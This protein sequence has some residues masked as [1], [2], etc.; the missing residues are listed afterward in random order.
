MSRRELNSLIRE[1]AVTTASRLRSGESAQVQRD[2]N[3]DQ[4]VD[5][6]QETVS[7]SQ[8]LQ[9]KLV[10]A[11]EELETVRADYEQQLSQTR[12]AAERAK[13]ENEDQRHKILELKHELEEETQRRKEV[14]C[15][16]AEVSES[17]N[18][19][20][21]KWSADMETMRMRIELDGLKQLEEVRRQ[22]DKERE[23]HREELERDATLI[24]ELKRK[25]ATL[26]S[27]VPLS[28][29]GAV[30]ELH[31]VNESSSK[32]DGVSSDQSSSSGV[33]S[34]KG[35]KESSGHGGVKHVTFAEPEGGRSS[36][37]QT[38]SPPD[39]G[40]SAHSGE[41]G[42][43][44]SGD[45]NPT[46]PASS[47]DSAPRSGD[48]GST[49]VD[50]MTI[51]GNAG[52]EHASEVSDSTGDSVSVGSVAGD[53]GLLMQQLTQ[54]VQTQT[55]M[56]V[57]QTR[58]MSAQGLPP[59][60]HYSGE[61]IQSSEEGFDRWIEQFE[62]RAKLVGWSEDHKRYNLKML[63]DKSAFQTY[64]LLP[65]DVK[66]SYSATVEALRSRFKPV[67]IEELR[68]MEFH[69]LIQTDQSVE[70]LGLAL[71]RLAKRA[72]P[73][74]KGKDFD[75]LVK[76]RFFQA[77]LPRWQ[78]KLGA[79]KP[80][81]SFDELFNRAR[82]TERREQQYCEV[83][84]ERKDAQQ[85][86]K[87][88]EKA[89]TQ[90]R[91]EQAEK[92][93]NSEKR[94][95][96]SK[97]GQGQGP[98]CHNCHRYGHIAKFCWDK[99]KRGAEA[100]GKQKDSKTHLVTCVD[101]LSDKELEQELSKRR[102]DK[103][104]QL[105]SDCVES[106]VNIV[107]GAVGPSYWLQISVEG[108][109][110]SA[111]VDTGSQSTII[112]RSLLHKVFLHLK[113]HGK[114]LPTL[115]YPC[116][117]F[118]GKGGHPIGVSAQVLF[119]LS[120]DGKSTT[121]P[122]FVQ[123]DSEQE[124]LLG[125]NVLPALGISLVRANGQKFT[126]SIENEAEPAHINLVQSVT[127]PG[128]KGRFVKGRI[129][130]DPS[131][132][133]HLLFEPK[134]E[135]LEPLGLC[136]QESI[137]TVHS[138]GSVLIPLQNFQGMPVRLERGA[139][140]GVA[141]Q[142]NL[143][144]QVNIDV[145][146]TVDSELPHDHSRCATVKALVN[147]PERLEKLLKALDLPV[148]KL[149]PVELEKLKEVLAESTDVFALDDSELGCTGLVQHSIDT[150]DHHPVKQPPYRTPVV[151]REKIEQ[152]VSDMQ[153][154]GVVKPSHSPWAS[155]IVL[156]PKKDGS[157][158]FCVDFRRL[159]SLTRKDVY[160]LPRVED[161]LDTL[162]EAKYFTSLDLASGYWQVELDQDARAKSAFTT[163]HG[164]FE[165][166]RMPF[167]LCNA[168]ATFQRLMQAVLSGLEW[169]SCFA[170]LDDILIASRTFDDHL[171][172]LREVFGR[173]REA[174]LRLKPK[175]CL[176][177]RDEVP[178]LGHV[179]STQGI[180]PDPSK[181]EKV[182][183]FP[184]PSDVTTLRQFVGL[185]SYYRRF[186]PGFAKIAAPLHALTKKDVPFEWTQECEAAFC[187]LKELLITAPVLAYPRFGHDKEF[188]LETD[189][190]GIGLGAVLS[191][192]QDDGHLHPIAY[193]SRS[194]N[195]HEKNYCI[196][197]L[198][199]LGLVWAVRYFR[200]Y[201]LGHHTTVYTDH[202]ACLSLLNTPRPSGKL[203]RWALT[204][205]E[206]NLTL[207]HRS[208][209]QNVNA[210]ALSR[211]PVTDS[212]ISNSNEILD[213][214]EESKSVS[215]VTSKAKCCDSVCPVCFHCSV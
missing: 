60:Q 55:A 134:Y 111:L 112:S 25:L 117:K 7:D 83:A 3:E 166:V 120:V 123:P 93:S 71:Q 84:E 65:D 19:V 66:A 133:E 87:K 24:A 115:D 207:K 45:S 77:L 122:V 156:V 181:T 177:L 12:E 58:A 53:K 81:E 160:P 64:R 163:H 188:I 200:P 172:H 33:S 92:A 91:K 4:T 137:L 187:K 167:G 215:V 201:L 57:A 10:M 42:G 56:V 1:G 100:P 158:R 145:P 213:A 206:M 26:E 157:L 61:G 43:E 88:V 37:G 125:S 138:D 153:K 30:S 50:V 39:S 198:E 203:A 67:D 162:G 36:R 27:A 124:C 161:I 46:E 151:Y 47:T 142:C 185:A 168:P 119:T 184:T 59:M 193:A 154:Q 105:A 155:P 29:P 8:E 195:P 146:Q 99:Q 174:G 191:Q 202:S 186:V 35:N 17:V 14:E 116:T 103:E 78:R 62:E 102:L 76:G 171:R 113:K 211:N 107:T 80:D 20:N 182:K 164:L 11:G 197:E 210:D 205:Q 75:R 85:K 176:L 16:L 94:E 74:L 209:R 169:R 108:L 118:K 141:R 51:N 152:M 196:S 72:F 22:F 147:S 28:D 109:A 132:L 82:T 38:E 48:L 21:D 5:G 96:S 68:G 15:E 44:N 144:D 63:L 128:Q 189:A 49:S 150:G 69:Q 170:Y 199:T 101:E 73:M 90:P 34:G 40:D 190:S 86:T 135:S 173:L 2:M 149:N 106:S 95:S 79:P 208:G 54:L 129:E 121:V 110:V 175:K 214:C 178:Y 159:N 97:Q 13:E 32:G 9:Q 148:D 98:Q 180:R 130:G 143:P 139:E 212:N 114:T 140:L 183:L 70:A 89:P 6:M 126:A 131:K 23:R 104:Q 136:T 165:F 179:I 41:T 127:I 18:T 52:G 31:G 194:L 204:I 192:K